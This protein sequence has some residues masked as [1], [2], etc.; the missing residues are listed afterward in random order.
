VHRT[1]EGDG[2]HGGEAAASPAAGESGRERTV[3]ESIVVRADPMTLWSRVSDPVQMGS[4]SP[5][6]LGA[7]VDGEPG[8]AYP[9]MTFDGHN[10]RGR[11][12][13]TTRCTVT[14][15]EP[16]VRFAFRVH[17]LGLRRPLLS[18]RIATWEYRF[19][20]VEGGTLVTESWCD[21]RVAWPRPLVRWFDRLTTGGDDFT[22]FQ[23]ANIRTTLARLASAV[24]APEQG[25]SAVDRRGPGYAGDDEPR[26]ETDSAG[27]G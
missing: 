7:T 27:T 25:G 16:G 6:N 15:A 1:P 2:H 9:G 26:P 11:L 19:E 4:W 22:A 14:A 18:A 12:R 13:W 17:G 10:K 23:R 5:E 24:G 3:V 8:R 21:D 20:P